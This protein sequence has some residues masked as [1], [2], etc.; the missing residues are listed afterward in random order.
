MNYIDYFII[1]FILIYS[2]WGLSK[3]II[4]IVFD[5]LGY[6]VAIFTAK[7]LSP[8]LIQYVNSTVIY[9]KI[10]TRVFESVNKLDPIVSQK[11]STYKIPS[12]MSGILNKEPEIINMLK[13]F[14]SL[15]ESIENN[16]SK[17]SGKLM[18]DI[19]ADYVV[20]ILCFLTVFII[21]KIIF[22]IVVAIIISRNEDMPLAVINRFLGL[23][24]GAITSILLLS[25]IFQVA[26]VLTLTSANIITN[27]V[28]ESKYG[29]LFINLP[30]LEW[31]SNFITR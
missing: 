11:L 4:K 22:S 20:L 12:D 2:L 3:G 13:D 26:E 25:L 28:Q 9:E 27:A 15:L 18:L 29:H 8:Y 24:L 10:Q 21:V 19:I 23:L 5:L 30:I 7:L 14:P 16:I 17:F 1:G 6:I 31:I